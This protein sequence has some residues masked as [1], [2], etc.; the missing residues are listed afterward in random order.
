[1]KYLFKTF[2]VF[3]AI[4]FI[5]SHFAVAERYTSTNY[6]IE[7]DSINFGGELSTSTNYVLEDTAGEVGTGTSSSATYKIKAGYQQMEVVSIAITSPADVDLS[8]AINPSTGGTSLGSASWRVT[9]N[10]DT[11]YTLSI[12]ASTNPAMKSGVNSFANYT[13]S[14]SVPDYTWSVVS[15]AYEFGFTP[16]GTDI[17]SVY[18]DNGVACSTG[19]SDTSSACWDSITTTAKTISSLGVAN[20]P[21]G[22]ST[23]TARFTAEAGLASSP[24]SG[25]YIAT[26][27]LTAV[28]Q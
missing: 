27:T 24:P 14:G 4:F 23:T 2:F 6:I 25:S 12:E 15:T 8:P 3:T 10:N 11:G 13:P 1:M 22:G 21:T 26:I 17:T 5:N 9:T 19:S 28:T 18:K 20:S 16:E 7:R